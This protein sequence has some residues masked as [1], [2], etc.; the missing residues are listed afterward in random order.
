MHY[1]PLRI[2]SRHVRHTDDELLAVEHIFGNTPPARQ[3][4]RRALL[5]SF[6]PARRK[7]FIISARYYIHGKKS[8]VKPEA[9]IA[10]T[11]LSNNE[12]EIVS[13]ILYTKPFY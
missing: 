5:L 12:Y 3:Y 9:Q 6:D 1:S 11:I 7:V 4:F 10:Y 13:L 2:F 8:S